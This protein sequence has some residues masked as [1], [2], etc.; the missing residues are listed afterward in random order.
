[1]V[2]FR[3]SLNH[4]AFW[5][6]WNPNSISGFIEG[7]IST[8]TE[9]AVPLFF[10]ISGFFFF[11]K[12][13]YPLNSYLKMITKKIKSLII[14]FLIWNF[15]GALILIVTHKFTYENSLFD[16]FVTLLRS[17]WYGPLWY[18]RTLVIFMLAYPSYGWIACC[19]STQL[20]FAC[21]LIALY[22]WIPV[23]C[24]WISTEGILFFLIGGYLSQRHS[25]TKIHISGYTVTI[26]FFI[27][28]IL[29]FIHPFWGKNIWKFN[30]ILGIFI[31]WQMIDFIPS[32]WRTKLLSIASYSFFIFVNHFYLLKS[33]KVTLASIFPQNEIVALSAYFLLPLITIII[34]FYIGKCWYKHYPTSYLFVTG[35]RR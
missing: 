29:C 34:L 10:T 1:M 14:P 22:F 32:K 3:H 23:D 5:G 2:V 28:I 24:N 9:V 17:D 20:Y 7:G 6:Q 21:L 18:I 11:S 26:M 15:V 19:N 30:T 13:Y 35:G 31:F 8:L 25:M 16:Y 12:T 33:M 4:I 27:W